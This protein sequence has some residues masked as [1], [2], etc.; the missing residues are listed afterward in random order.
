MSSMSMEENINREQKP[1]EGQGKHFEANTGQKVRRMFEDG[2]V[3]EL[4]DAEYK[5]ELESRKEK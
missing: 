3:A 4:T 5:T 2:T 1:M